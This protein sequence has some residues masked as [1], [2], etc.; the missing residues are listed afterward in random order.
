MIRCTLR[1]ARAL[2]ALGCAAAMTC[3]ANAQNLLSN[4]S[5]EIDGPGFVVFEDWLQF[6]NVFEDESIEV[7]AQDGLQSAKMFGQFTPEGQSDNGLQ[8]VVPVIGGDTYTLTGWTYV[9]SGDAIQPLDPMGSPGGGAFGHLALGIIDFLDSGG[10]VIAGQSVEVQVHESGVTATDNWVQFS[11][12]GTAP[13]NAMDAQVTLLLIQWDLA[14]GAIFWDNLSLEAGM[15]EPQ[16][17]SP[18]DLAEPFG[19]LDFSD[20]LAFLGFFGAGCP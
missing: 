20:V 2:I 5:L 18:A 6:N 7:L 16:P 8:Q 15:G 3:G 17:C 4:P 14:P 19:V 13:A 10:G 12:T 11:V 1:P 9:P